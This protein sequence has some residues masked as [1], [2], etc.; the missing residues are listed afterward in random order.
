MNE[1]IVVHLDN[2]TLPANNY[3]Y[4]ARFFVTVRAVGQS[5]N[6]KL[7]DANTGEVHIPFAYMA[8][9][10]STGGIFATRFGD[11]RPIRLSQAEINDLALHFFGL[12]SFGTPIELSY[13]AL[14][15]DY[16]AVP[17]PTNLVPLNGSIVTSS[18]PAI[19]AS[20][21]NSAPQAA[22]SFA[23]EWQFCQVN[24]FTGGTLKTIT[25]TTYGS[26]KS[27]QI[28]YPAATA[29]LTQGLWYMRVRTLVEGTD[30]VSA[31]TATTSFTV[32]HPPGI[33]SN[34]TPSGGESLAYAASVPLTFRF[35]DPW[36]GLGEG[37][38]GDYTINVDTLEGPLTGLPVTLTGTF[39]IDG[40]IKS[41]SLATNAAWKDKALIWRVRTDDEDNATGAT[42]GYN[43]FYIRDPPTIAVTAPTASEVVL[44][45]TPTFEWTVTASEGRTQA[46]AVVRVYREGV[47]FY[48]AN[49]VGSALI[50]TPDFPILEPDLDYT[51][52]VQV[53]DT[54]GVTGISPA[55]A[56][57]ADIDVP[58]TPIFGLDDSRFADEGLI[59]VDWAGSTS[60]AAILE[61]RILRREVGTGVWERIAT[62]SPSLFAYEDWLAPSHTPLEYAVSQVALSFGMPIESA[63]V[64]QTITPGSDRYLIVCPDDPTL[65][66]VVNATGESFNEEYEEST[67]NLIGRGRRHEIGTRY[68]YSGT[69]TAQ[70]YDDETFTGRQKRLKLEYM[71]SAGLRYYLRNPFGDVWRIALTGLSFERIAGTSGLQEYTTASIS[72][73]EVAL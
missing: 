15:M 33:A 26:T 53:T 59:T 25:E 31:W 27:G 41:V 5:S 44:V 56:F 47:L 18:R 40:N 34:R 45:A 62:V 12:G 9:T 55:Q 28:A 32:A 35:N 19:G 6:M 66:I 20:I 52:T 69:L 23:R 13:A 67:L 73:I 8:I 11:Y 64:P 60:E 7:A 39:A 29:R 58:D 43:V 48:T 2:F 54:S 30:S 22:D 38:I 51:V 46:S 61:W 57:T 68:G 36:V 49:I 10:P 42:S 70:L 21:V 17:V 14:Q 63:I 16:Q 72:Y 71:R 65:N 4:Q 37:L 24:T 1:G 3:V 50:H